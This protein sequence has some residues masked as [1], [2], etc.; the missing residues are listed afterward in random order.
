MRRIHGFGVV[1]GF[2]LVVSAGMSAWGQAPEG[3][4]TAAGQLRLGTMVPQ[5][6]I[7]VLMAP[8]VQKEL[9]LTDAQ[10]TK[11]Y[12]LALTSGQKQRDLFQAVLFSGG[13]SPQALL[14][15]RDQLRGENEQAIDRILEP[16]QQE[17]LEQIVLQ[18]EG[19]LAVS[20]PKVADRLR[21]NDRQREVVQ[22]TM[23]Q[24]QVG[25]RQLNMA[26]RRQAVQLNQLDP[27]Q[28]GQVRE[29]MSRLR[30]EAVKQ[31]SKVID[32][33]QKAQFNKMLG[34]PF[35]LARLD[36]DAKDTPADEKAA[37]AKDEVKPST[38]PASDSETPKSKGNTRPARRKA[39][40]K[41][42]S[43]SR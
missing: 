28:F 20:R 27:S 26:A 41:T 11:V 31:I 12:D 19:P 32:A 35:D 17:R 2:T 3:Q 39:R 9:K 7:T 29:A 10:K 8:A 40:S 18:L 14:M 43:G 38:P 22:A 21:L 1:L 13:T 37:K 33:K 34:E 6:P 30:D 23:M 16:K 25:Q 24:L 4:G 15:A 5:T 36:A 42:G